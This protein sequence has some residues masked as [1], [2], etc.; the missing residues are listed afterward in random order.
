MGSTDRGLYIHNA[1]ALPTER[2]E[3]AKATARIV[4]LEG[5]LKIDVAAARALA[6]HEYLTQLEAKD[7]MIAH[8]KFELEKSEMRHD[9]AL[10]EKLAAAERL[11]KA[12][13]TELARIK[14]KLE[15]AWEAADTLKG[16]L[17]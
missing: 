10:A 8:L 13:D 4:E 12:Q 11:I 1:W 16:L 6:T 5:Q 3:L 15:D 2:V 7:S 9:P 17:A 14:Q